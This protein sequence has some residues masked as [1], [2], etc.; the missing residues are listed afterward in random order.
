MTRIK[1]TKTRDWF[2]LIICHSWKILWVDWKADID[3][4]EQ[5]RF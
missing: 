1:L 4:K 3:W 5:N 2:F